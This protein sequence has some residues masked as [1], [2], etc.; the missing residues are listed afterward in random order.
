MTAAIP[1]TPMSILAAHSPWTELQALTVRQSADHEIRAR[2]RRLQSTFQGCTAIATLFLA[3]SALAHAGEVQLPPFVLLAA[4]VAFAIP[5]IRTATRQSNDASSLRRWEIE[6]G[7]LP[8][9]ERQLTLLRATVAGGTDEASLAATAWLAMGYTLRQ[10][11]LAPLREARHLRGLPF[12][13]WEIDEI[14][15]VVDGTP[16]FAEAAAT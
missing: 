15:Y 14:G 11:D 1:A 3:L 7:F 8:L 10:R 6:A 13:H 16:Q 5:A 2:V 12:P 9:T 4:G